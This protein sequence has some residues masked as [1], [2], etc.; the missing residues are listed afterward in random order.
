MSRNRA[1][2]TQ[3]ELALRRALW[4]AGLRGYRTH[5]LGVPGRPD[6]AFTRA[7][8]A[9]FVHGCF[10][11]G[12]PEHGTWPRSNPEYWRPKIEGNVARDRATDAALDVAGWLAIR[13]WEHEPVCEAADRIAT[14][15]MARSA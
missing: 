3:P 12:C 4:A 13:V 7:R 8:V 15:V 6:V 9:V 11:H 1:R 2:D 5:A 14:A 10:W